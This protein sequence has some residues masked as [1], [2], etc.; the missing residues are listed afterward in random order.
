VFSDLSVLTNVRLALQRKRGRSFDFWRS[1]EALRSFNAAALGILEDFG[2]A[3]FADLPA[4][5]LAYGHK[6]ALEL[7][8]TMAL[9]PKMLLLDEPTAGMGREDYKRIESLIGKAAVD[10]TILMVEHNLSV[11]A[12][13]ADRI[14]VLA[15]G[16]VLADGDYDT[17]AKDRRVIEAYLGSGHHD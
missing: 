7:A 16:Q 13:L 3:Q 1:E 10:R 17:V 4:K 14:T 15:R 9:E 11:V 6:R 5:D 2:I 8:T 12:V